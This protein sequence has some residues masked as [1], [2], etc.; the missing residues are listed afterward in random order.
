[1]FS[2][3]TLTALLLNCAR[4][5][6]NISQLL[7]QQSNIV[8]ELQQLR[9]IQENIQQ[10]LQQG[11]ARGLDMS[12][13]KLT[14]PPEYTAGTGNRYTSISGAGSNEDVKNIDVSSEVEEQ[15][16]DQAPTSHHTGA[17]HLFQ[18]PYIVDYFKNAGITS[19]E[20]VVEETERSGTL[21]P[22]GFSH[23][24]NGQI[25]DAA[26]DEGWDE[27]TKEQ[28]VEDPLEDMWGNGL[29]TR[30]LNNPPNIG[31]G[32]PDGSLD[33]VQ[34]T[35]WRLYDS[36]MRNMWVLHPFLDAKWLNAK[37]EEFVNNHS[38][39]FVQQT[40]SE[41]HFAVPGMPASGGRPGTPGSTIGK[42]KRQSNAS[43]DGVD[44]APQ[45]NHRRWQAPKKT[46]DRSMQNAI[47]LLVL[48][49]GKVLMEER[50]LLEEFSTKTGS[51][52]P[53]ESSHANSPYDASKPSPR[54]HTGYENAS[55]PGDIKAAAM[56]RA[57][58]Y[59]GHKPRRPRKNGRVPN[60]ELF[61]GLAYFAH[62]SDILGNNLG[63]NSIMHG[64]AFLLAGIY[65]GQLGRVTES[66]SW[67]NE[68]LRVTTI[69]S[70]KKQ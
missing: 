34:D 40:H 5:D 4:A 9:Q 33:L 32:N 14:S 52:D 69:L 53:S 39:H 35:V 12:Q 55:S 56:A 48:A 6:R 10:M 38:P 70:N 1:M 22:Y 37:I 64:Q 67:I 44:Y 60:T 43:E 50:F 59:E 65:Y 2:L 51:T 21:R 3:Q 28:I 62:A 24:E 66:W 47:I 31:G 41:G 16:P 58:S 19:A 57:A 20:Y 8:T 26:Q 11:T 25:L 46:P 13:A 27:Y 36:Y 42:R 30:G 18:W 61:P 63:G 23:I 15:V 45:E 54:S 17:Q 68:G 29:S 49:L 7:D